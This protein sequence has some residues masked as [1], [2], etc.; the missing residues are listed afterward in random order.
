MSKG[1]LVFSL[2]LLVAGCGTSAPTSPF[3][4][5]G[6]EG[7][8]RT[9]LL[10]S[11][12]D[13]R[14]PAAGNETVA[15]TDEDRALA[16]GAHDVAL[17]AAANPTLYWNRLTTELAAAKKLPPPLFARAYA[18]VHA[19]IADALVSTRDR[20]R[21]PLSESAVA[22]GAAYE[23]L[24]YLFPDAAERISTEAT[25]QAGLSERSGRVLGGWAL[26]RAVGRLAVDHGKRDGSD[27]AFTGPMPTGPGIWTGTNP[28]LPLCGTW[29]CWLIPAGADFRPE[30]PYA[31]GSAED[32]KDIADVAQAALN[33]TPE[34]V[35]IVHKWA[36]RSPPAIWNGLLAQRLEAANA[37]PVASAR[38]LAWLHT[39]MADAFVSC[40]STKYLY[41]V[42]RPFQRIPGLVTVIP[43]PNFPSYTSGHSTISGA[44]AE[45]MAELFPNEAGFFRA[46]A[47]EAAVSRFWG[48]I[49]FAHDDNEGLKVGRRIGVFAVGLMRAEKKPALVAAR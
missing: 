32:L 17:A 39:T 47:E 4:D 6:P 43:T 25:A 28:L 16:A 41:W 9:F 19:G 33:R 12:L 1:I 10:A 37:D 42:A 7:A 46:Q 45:V 38:A 40:W 22:A 11:S 36:D 24:R 20:R 34:Q 30:P 48:G 27:A 44:A 31:Y 29:K 26:G 3:A 21:G 13:S 35:E 23:I 14:L 5:R 49:H 2:A 18:L 8:S 15:L